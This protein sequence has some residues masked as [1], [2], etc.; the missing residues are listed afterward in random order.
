MK[1]NGGFISL[2]AVLVVAVV[3]VSGCVQQSQTQTPATPT[4]L[5]AVTPETPATPPAP[6]APP[7]TT[8][9]VNNCSLLTAKDV[10]SIV[11]MAVKQ[12]PVTTYSDGTC[13][14]GWVDTGTRMDV[15]ASLSLN[16]IA[17]ADSI[18]SML[19][20]AC[21]NT[22][23][24]QLSGIGDYASCWTKMPINAVFFGK[25]KYKFEAECVGAQ[26][27]KKK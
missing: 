12:S 17:D 5:P 25:G 26:C 7:A 14:I 13:V 9:S 3:F 8:Y 10:E 4:T 1:I 2:L 21:V 24:E 18:R 16:K 23:M 15:S 19:T 27:S 20:S 6:P 11:G 22:D